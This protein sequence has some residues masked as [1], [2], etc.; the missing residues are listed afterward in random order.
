MGLAA[1]H[2]RG[3]S[4]TTPH[5]SDCCLAYRY[6]AGGRRPEI[7]GLRFENL[8]PRGVLASELLAR[9]VEDLAGF[10]D[11]RFRAA[12]TTTRTTLN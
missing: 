5:R 10:L 4:G 8:I 3:R 6:V 2:W 9:D 12:V 1:Q 11:R 7:K